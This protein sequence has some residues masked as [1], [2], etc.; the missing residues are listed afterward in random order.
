MPIDLA[1]A[2]SHE[3]RKSLH[4]FGVWPVGQKLERG[5]YGTLEGTLFTALGNVTAFGAA[6]SP[7]PVGPQLQFTF[8]SKEVTQGK[9]EAK[10]STKKRLAQLDQPALA[11][12]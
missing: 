10:A 6:V 3:T 4:M 11:L 8:K 12:S 9:L 7:N 5:T 2:F 1:A